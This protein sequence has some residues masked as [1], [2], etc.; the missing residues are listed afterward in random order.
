M[1]DKMFNGDLP[2][3][4][5]E[6][7]ASWDYLYNFLVWLS[8]FFFVLIVGGMIYFAYKYRSRPGLKTKYMTGSHILEIIWIVLP[9]LLLLVI[10]G[11]GYSVYHAITQAPADSMEI[12]VIAKQWLWQFQYDNGRTTIGDAYVPMNRPVKFIMTSEDVLHSMFVPNFRVKQ[13]VVP[14]MY[15]SVWFEAKMPGKHQI[16]C[17][18]YCGTS[19]SGMLGQ[20][21]AL[22]EAQWK[23]WYA[24]KKI[25]P[26][27]VAGRELGAADTQAAPV[28]LRD[29]GKALA[30]SKGCIAC[31]SDDGTTKVGPSYKGLF[32]AKVEL[33]DGSTVTADEN[34]LRES[35][36]MPQAKIVKGFQPVMPTFK[37][38]LSETEMNALMVYIKSLK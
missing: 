2:H 31:H 4:A 21:I 8:V 20:V 12:R 23:A 36:E 16:F 24:G 22:D 19:H 11:W 9:T 27:P 32:G 30:A 33:A 25:G 17:T 7:A 35:I 1:F 28:S 10:F 14:G 6:L 29:Q 38:L 37:G 34:Y 3:R 26:V 5:T 15:T 18:E 13:D